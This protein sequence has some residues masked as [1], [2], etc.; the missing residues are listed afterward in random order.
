LFTNLE[1]DH[2]FVKLSHKNTYRPKVYA[3]GYSAMMNKY[4]VDSVGKQ[5]NTNKHINP[6]MTS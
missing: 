5:N 3:Y 6:F 4:V 2:L 1:G